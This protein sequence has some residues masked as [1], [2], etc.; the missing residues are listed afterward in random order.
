MR[1]LRFF[2]LTMCA[3]LHKQA[4]AQTFNARYDAWGR[5][6]MG[7]SVELLPDSTYVIFSNSSYLDSLLYSSVVTSIRINANGE[8]LDT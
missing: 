3:G 6:D 2:L 7:W 5:S 8:P 4:S 1:N